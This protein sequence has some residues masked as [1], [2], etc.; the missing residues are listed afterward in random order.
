MSK[1]ATGCF[2]EGRSMVY[3]V[4]GNDSQF[5]LRYCSTMHPVLEWIRYATSCLEWK[6]SGTV[7]IDNQRKL[8]KQFRNCQGLGT[9]IIQC[10]TGWR[11]RFARNGDSN[12]SCVCRAYPRA[13]VVLVDC[14]QESKQKSFWHL[15]QSSL[16]ACC[17][18]PLQQPLNSR[19]HQDDYLFYLSPSHFH[20][21]PVIIQS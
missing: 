14:L 11:I 19:H 18:Q 1:H 21:S 2:F 9:G 8:S 12:G 13:F 6:D 17:H 10:E 4:T 15:A 20:I 7:R 5:E 16:N 3:V